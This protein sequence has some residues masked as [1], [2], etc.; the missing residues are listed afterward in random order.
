MLPAAAAALTEPLGN[1]AHVVRL[2]QHLKPSRVLVIGAGPIGLMCQQAIQAMLAAEV[3]VTDLSDARLDVARRLGAWEVI[4]ANRGDAVARV[5]EL[6]TGE[7]VDLV[8]DAVGAEI[9]K[10]QALTAL[11]PGGTAVWIGLHQNQISLESY[12]I[13][14][15]ERQVLGVYAAPPEDMRTALELMVSG[16]V[17]VSS[18]VKMT[19]LEDGGEVFRALLDNTESVIKA[20]LI[21]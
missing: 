18:W 20:V 15:G 6:T 19:S 8:V 10:R 13:T 4:P 21:P 2:T 1:G 17:D 14:L 11:R 9:T 3:V 7:G 16:K 5:L 12:E